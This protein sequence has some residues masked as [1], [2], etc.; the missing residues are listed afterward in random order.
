MKI[1]LTK[2]Q[3]AMVLSA[4]FSGEIDKTGGVA[5]MFK[6]KILA[7]VPGGVCAGYEKG[8]A[9]TVESTSALG[10]MLIQKGVIRG[11]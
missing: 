8:L 11:C 10:K 7:S 2:E 6:G 4:V 9:I 1:E 5:A 3:A